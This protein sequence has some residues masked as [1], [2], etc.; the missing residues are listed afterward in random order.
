MSIHDGAT[1]SEF[2]LTCYDE[3]SLFT[4]DSYELLAQ[5]VLAP[6]DF[7]KCQN[8]INDA[9]SGSSSVAVRCIVTMLGNLMLRHGAQFTIDGAVQ[10]L[11]EIVK[12]AE[13]FKQELNK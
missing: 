8:V 10:A 6:T 4:K 2:A 7:E 1:P 9:V 12:Y 13:I 5:R 11:D 3:S